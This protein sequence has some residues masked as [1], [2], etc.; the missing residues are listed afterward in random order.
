MNQ[1]IKF[2]TWYTY[3]T[4]ISLLY[5][6][7][8]NNFFKLFSCRLERCAMLESNTLVEKLVRIVCDAETI[9]QNIALDILIWIAVIRLGRLCG[10]RNEL[11]T[12][13]IMFIKVIEAHLG[14][15]IQSCF[16][17]GGRSIAHKCVKLFVVCSEW[18]FLLCTVFL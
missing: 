14:Q 3:V 4:I 17:K 5:V 2:Y 7:L 6:L 15:L 13:Q 12:Q 9:R 8:N 16:I 18:V 11:I 10:V 1:N